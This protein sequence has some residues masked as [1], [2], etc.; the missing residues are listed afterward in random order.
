MRVAEEIKGTV[1]FRCGSAG[2]GVL[3]ATA[4]SFIDTDLKAP[5][6]CWDRPNSR[7]E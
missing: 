5:V 4:P 1:T 6:Q 7:L 3:Q 2:T